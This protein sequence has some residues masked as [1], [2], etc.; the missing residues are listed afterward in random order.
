MKVTLTMIIGFWYLYCLAV[1]VL[2][3]R[4]KK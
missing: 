3:K 1:Y 2:V 4:R